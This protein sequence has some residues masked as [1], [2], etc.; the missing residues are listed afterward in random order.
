[1]LRWFGKVYRRLRRLW[2]LPP[3][4]PY[5]AHDSIEL[6][7]LFPGLYLTGEGIEIGALHH[8]MQVPQRVKVRYVDRMDAAGLRRH[9]PELGDAALVDPDIIDD[10][11]RLTRVPAASQDFVIA[12]HFLEHCQ[13]PLGTLEALFR[14]LKPGG[15]LY[16][17]LPDK[18]YT[19]D[20][21]RPVTPLAH[22]LEDHELGPERSWR[23]HAEEYVR[24]VNGA[25]EEGE[26]AR[27][28]E[29]IVSENLSIH[30]HV[31]TQKEML[32][33]LLAVKDRLDF[34]LETMCKNHMEVVFVL[35]KS[36]GGAG[37][38]LAA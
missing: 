27:A 22:L 25:T 30:F 29:R 34:D 16:M 18:R 32:E 7:R 11:E 37:V 12:N 2:K 33:L 17:G 5:E 3:P 1:M 20:H 19:F 31:W 4:P 36:A 35:R 28:T 38:S 14:V 26:V 23:S 8:P 13:D 15:V 24:L 6:V 9:Y 21:Q 10:G